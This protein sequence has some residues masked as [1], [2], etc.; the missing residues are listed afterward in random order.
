MKY[1]K[2]LTIL[3]F[4]AALAALFLSCEGPLAGAKASLKVSAGLAGSRG[5]A[6]ANLAARASRVEVLLASQDGH[7]S[8]S[9]TLQLPAAGP[10]NFDDLAPGPWTATGV[11][12]DANGLELGRATVNASLTPGG[13]SAISIPIICGASPGAS[14]GN[15]SIELT[16]RWYTSQQINGFS[17]QLVD[18]PAL[19]VHT[20]SAAGSTYATITGSNIPAGSYDLVMSF[21]RAGAADAGTIRASVNVWK[22]VTTDSWLDGS[23]GFESVWNL[24]GLLLE[25]DSVLAD[26][27]LHGAI[28]S[29]FS[30]DPYTYA[31]TSVVIGRYDDFSFTAKGST[32]GQA[33]SFSLNGEDFEAITSGDASRLLTMREGGNSLKIRVVSPDRAAN[34]EYVIE[35]DHRPTYTSPS[36]GLMVAKIPAGSWFG[37]PS[38]SFYAGIREVSQAEYQAVMGFN[39]SAL[40]QNGALPVNVVTF[41]D[42]IE[43]CNRL[44]DADGLQRVY[45]YTIFSAISN[46]NG[47]MNIVTMDGLSADFSKDGY[48]LPTE[49]EA[50]RLRMAGASTL[51]PW[52]DDPAMAADYAVLGGTSP[53]PVGSK[54]P[55]AW[56]V[57]DAVGN[58]AEWAWGSASS[59]V[60]RSVALG[61]HFS[62]ANASAAVNSQ[63]Y[64]GS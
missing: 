59:N 54:A 8:R 27:E 32:L 60:Q 11:A 21:T 38:E 34:R 9:G 5:T 41:Y 55:N 29:T 53:A 43:F 14:A 6:T 31:Y 40:P 20:E 49:I 26:L 3:G 12:Y 56:G 25:A 2:L 52:G 36:C 47:G 48:R 22:G 35:F 61:G 13:S 45:S 28:P 62:D 23:G 50:M 17:A 46:F 57:Y 15:G 39:P 7:P 10:L 64:A 58:I 42:A 1:L 30:F 4:L 37:R 51:Y 18:G 44:S 33:I 63:Y 19:A 24:S 16:V